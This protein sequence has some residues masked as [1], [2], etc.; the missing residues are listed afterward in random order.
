MTW[1]AGQVVIQNDLA[2]AGVLQYFERRQNLIFVILQRFTSD[3]VISLGL[4]EWQKEAGGPVAVKWM[5]A[6]VYRPAH[7][8]LQD[9][10]LL[11][12]W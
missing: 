1:N 10:T 7:W 9:S 5:P 4:C 11:T 6:D 8:L 12:I 2:W 3:R